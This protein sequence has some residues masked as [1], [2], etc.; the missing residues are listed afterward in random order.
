VIE[1]WHGDVER[2]IRLLELLDRPRLYVPVDP[3][4][5][6]RAAR[7]RAALPDLDVAPVPNL[8]QLEPEPRTLAF[9]PGTAIGC[10]AAASAV[11]LLAAF[12]EVASDLL[13]GG[14]ATSDPDALRRAYETRECASW[15]KHA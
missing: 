14:D 8:A 7:V 6:V 12:G 3:D 11:E 4:A 2:S 1:A 13:V 9:V 5:D 15:A 10:I